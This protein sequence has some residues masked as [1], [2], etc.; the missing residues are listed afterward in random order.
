MSLQ[1]RLRILVGAE[2]NPMSGIVKVA[3]ATTDRKHVNQHFGSAEAFAIYAIGPEQATLLEVAQFVELDQDGREQKLP[4]KLMV[5]EECVAIYCTAVG[6]SAIRQLLA[7]DIQPIR[8]DE[9]TLITS[10]LRGLTM[11][12]GEGSLAWLGK[13][14]QRRQASVAGRFQAMEEE[15]W[16]E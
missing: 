3:F 5:L 9:G 14:M 6:G 7:R 8:V 11:A 4:A 10:V 15:G 1:R 2:D 16:R 12:V 13:A